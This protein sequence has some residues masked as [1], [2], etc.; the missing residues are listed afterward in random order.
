MVC[1]HGS[2]GYETF[3]EHKTPRHFSIFR[4]PISRVVSL[5]NHI[6]RRPNHRLHVEVAS[7]NMT[8]EEF[9]ENDVTHE[10]DNGMLRDVHP[11]HK[12][13]KIDHELNEVDESIFE[14]ARDEILNE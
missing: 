10:I 11:N 3:F 8:L 6:K 4:E 14:H 2:Y 9:V 5:Y 12:K 7:N 1:G 13:T